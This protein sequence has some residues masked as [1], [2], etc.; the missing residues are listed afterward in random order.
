[1]R[2][3]AYLAN[4]TSY[5]VRQVGIHI[6]RSGHKSILRAARLLK[7]ENFPFIID[8]WGN[9]DDQ[10]PESIP[11]ANLE[12]WQKAGL[13]NLKGYCENVNEAYAEGHIAILPS[14]REGLPK[15]LLEA[16]ACG[17]AIITTNTPGCREAIQEHKT[18]WLVPVKDPIV[19]AKMMKEKGQNL[20]DCEEKGLKGRQYVQTFFSTTRIQEALLKLYE[21]ILKQSSI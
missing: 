3:C 9:Q 11:S 5:P 16:A 18:G 12:E 20:K 14:Y 8:V 15:S 21:E 10:N 6:S 17:R 7:Q 1:M 2:G 13:I 4:S 19:L